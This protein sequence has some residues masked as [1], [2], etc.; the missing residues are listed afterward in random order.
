MAF[1]SDPDG[2]HAIFWHLFSLLLMN[3]LQLAEQQ[4]CQRK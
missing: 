3:S 2:R 4:S 1:F